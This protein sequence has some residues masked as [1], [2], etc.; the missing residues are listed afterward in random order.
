MWLELP[1]PAV[2]ALNSGGLA[3]LQLGLA[4]AFQRLPISWFE[5]SGKPPAPSRR[6]ALIRRWKDRAWMPDLDEFGRWWRAR[7]EADIDVVPQGAGW[8]LEVNAP[9]TLQNLT[10]LLPKSSHAQLR[11]NG[12]TGHASVPLG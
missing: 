4:W 8:S 3:A 9:A 12:V 1:W 10:V 6:S 11:L 5:H 2:T 7:D